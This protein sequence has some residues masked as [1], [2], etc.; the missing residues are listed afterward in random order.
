MGRRREF[1]EEISLGEAEREEEE[2]RE[3]E[4]KEKRRGG[5][6]APPTLPLAGV[7]PVELLRNLAGDLDA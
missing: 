6:P 7:S 5:S 3:E 4:E 2:R 1:R